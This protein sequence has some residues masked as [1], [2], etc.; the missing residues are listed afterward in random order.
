MVAVKEY[1]CA[2][3][4][5]ANMYLVFSFRRPLQLYNPVYPESF[6]PATWILWNRLIV[7]SIRVYT[8]G[9]VFITPAVGL[10][11]LNQAGV[12]LS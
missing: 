5:F 11:L 8:E 10:V 9:T 6:P 1:F 2:L 12:A 7:L 4:T 3:N